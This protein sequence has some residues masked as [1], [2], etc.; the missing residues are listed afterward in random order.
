MSFVVPAEGDMPMRR[1][2]NVL[3]G[4][5]EVGGVELFAV[6]VNDTGNRF[7]VSMATG[8]AY[9]LYVLTP[10]QARSLAGMLF[11]ALARSG[12][13]PTRTDQPIKLN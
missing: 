1:A 10:E 7:L 4:D 2:E 12:R 9:A 8:D 11:S 5:I 13:E 6:G 3:P